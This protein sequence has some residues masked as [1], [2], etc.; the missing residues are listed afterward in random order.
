MIEKISKVRHNIKIWCMTGVLKI[1]LSGGKN[2]KWREQFLKA[3]YLK[4]LK[5]CSSPSSDKM[6]QS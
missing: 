5:D 1:R 4:I 3:I 6:C 2:W